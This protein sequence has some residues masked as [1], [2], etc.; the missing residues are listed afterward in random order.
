MNPIVQQQYDELL[1]AT[2]DAKAVLAEVDR[3]AQLIADVLMAG[4]KVLTA[5]HGGVIKATVGRCLPSR[6]RRMAPR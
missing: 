5:G 6:L 2:A 3:C 1:R 4:G